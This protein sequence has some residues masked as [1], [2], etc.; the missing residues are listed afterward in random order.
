M[1]SHA[2]FAVGPTLLTIVQDANDTLSFPLTT[3]VR[4]WLAFLENEN[5]STKKSNHFRYTFYLSKQAYS[6]MLLRGSVLFFAL[7]VA[8]TQAFDCSKGC[9]LSTTDVAVCGDNGI[10]Y[11]NACIATCQVCAC[12]EM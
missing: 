3:E 10:T 2:S 6:I 1:L 12:F 5:D 9:A 4:L 11:S 7:L 8:S